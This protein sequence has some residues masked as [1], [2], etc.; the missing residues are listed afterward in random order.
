V[1]VL[2]EVRRDY[3]ANLESTV[4]PKKAVDNL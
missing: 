3:V 4:S 1:A 2:T